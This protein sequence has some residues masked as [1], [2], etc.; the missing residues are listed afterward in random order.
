M[1]TIGDIIDLAVQIEQNGE[2]LLRDAAKEAADPNLASMLNWLAD[3][4]IQ[5]V[6]RFTEMKEKAEETVADPKLED[7]GKAVLEV[8]LGGQTFSLK[9]IDFTSLEG[10]DAL[11]DRIIEFENDTI[12][13]YEMIR[14]F[15]QDQGTL[16]L[17]DAIIQEEEAH[18]RTL[19]EFAD[20]EAAK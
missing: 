15:V 11:L 7:M 3:E 9:D 13:F 2:K 5:H 17:L 1:F 19:R 8:T 4:E 6:D 20:G 12:L 10:V 16:D 14:S 18:I